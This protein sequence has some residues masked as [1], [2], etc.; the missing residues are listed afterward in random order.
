MLKSYFITVVSLMLSTCLF[1]QLTP[2]DLVKKD[3]P[4]TYGTF[5]KELRSK[6]LNFI[7]VLDISDKKFGNEIKDVVNNFLKPVKD[8]DYFNVIL[9]GSTDKTINLTECARVSNAK[10]NDISS[11]INKTVFGTI[12][13][14]GVK[15]TGLVLDALSCSGASNATPI[16]FIFSDFVHYDNG[17]S[18][19]GVRYWNPLVSRYETTKKNI[20]KPYVYCIELPNVDRKAQYLNNLKQIFKDLS[21]VT[22]SSASL[23]EDKFNDIRA[24]ITKKLLHD[25]V[26]QKSISQNLNISLENNDG[27]VVLKGFNALV[28]HKLVL[29]NE[30]KVEVSQI[31]N[32]EL[33]YSFFPP[34][35]TE[36]EVS[37]TLVAEKYKNEIPELANVELK[38]QKISLMIADSLIPWWLTDIIVI[39]LLFS[40]FRFIWTIIPPARLRGS[41]DFF[42]QGKSTIVIDCFGNNKKFS[43]NEVSL[44][45]NDFSLE[46]RATKKFFTG[47]CLVIY[48]LNGD[49]LLDSRKVKKTAPRGKK[50]IAS[51]RSKWTVDGINITMP[52]VK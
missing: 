52:N 41:I 32:S 20:E 26:I 15:M 9:L 30:S 17:W 34:T 22:C 1:G 3:W 2:E 31:L 33:L 50:T 7:F 47:K 10:K 49:L 40:I 28:Y 36:I 45:K 12:G 43:N 44:L 25:F 42:T 6:P 24:K 5:G 35:E 39:I 29:D 16:V 21:T 23:L 51:T 18:V 4:N 19:P 11:E 13:S 14:D 38:N 37:G 48:P 46:I 8:G 27:Q